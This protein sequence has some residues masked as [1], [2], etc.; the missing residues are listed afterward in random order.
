MKDDKK[1]IKV[2]CSFCNREMNC[3]EN[4][5]DSQKHVCSEC[6]LNPTILKQVEG[7]SKVHIDAELDSFHELIVNS[8]VEEVF[9]KLWKDRKKEL[10][11]LS[12]KELAEEMFGCGAYLALSNILSQS[13]EK[14]ELCNDIK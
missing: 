2:N 8:M 11:E 10:K 6:F 1:L 3:P 14:K 9:P 12:K 5:I 4:M 7:L 13:T